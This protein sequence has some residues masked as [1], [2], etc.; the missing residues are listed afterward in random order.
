VAILAR[1]HLRLAL[2]RLGEMASGGADVAQEESCHSPC[3]A[4]GHFAGGVI[5]ADVACHARFHHLLVLLSIVLNQG[6]RWR[7]NCQRLI[8]IL[9]QARLVIA[10]QLL[11]AA[12]GKHLIHF[13]TTEVRGS[14]NV[15]GKHPTL[16]CEASHEDAATAQAVAD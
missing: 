11:E 6:G 2:T 9:L 16:A 15:A 3:T 4:K 7:F 1:L 8:A 5:G 10:Q 14:R 12:I 13:K